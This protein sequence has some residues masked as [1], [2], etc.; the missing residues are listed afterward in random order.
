VQAIGFI[1]AIRPECI[2][3]ANQGEYIAKL[4]WYVSSRSWY[5]DE[6]LFDRCTDQNYRLTRASR[7]WTRGVVDL[8][9]VMKL[10]G[11]TAA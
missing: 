2:S 5:I 9:I 3:Q 11:Q 1:K 8:P 10:F 6:G 4:G 7:R